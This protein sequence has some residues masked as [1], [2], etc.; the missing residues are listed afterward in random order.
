MPNIYDIAGGQGMQFAQPFSAMVAA[1]QAKANHRL[2]EA[3]ALVMETN[4]ANDER[5]YALEDRKVKVSEAGIGVALERNQIDANEF[6]L[7]YEQWRDK[8]FNGMSEDAKRAFEFWEKAQETGA[9]LYDQAIEQGASEEEA[10]QIANAPFAHMQSQMPQNMRGQAL[11]DPNVGSAIRTRNNR[12]SN[13]VTSKQLVVSLPGQVPREMEVYRIGDKSYIKDANGNMTILRSDQMSSPTQ[14]VE[15]SNLELSKPEI[16]NL[17][18]AQAAGLNFVDGI[19]DAFEILE[20][21]DANTLTARGV[22]VVQDATNEMGALARLMGIKVSAST[23]PGD[24]EGVFKNANLAGEANARMR[25]LITSLAFQAALSYG[26][27]G[28]DVSN[29][30]VEKHIRE[31]G[32]NRSDPAVFKRLLVDNA[33]RIER[34]FKNRWEVAAQDDPSIGPYPE[35]MSK[36]V[37]AIKKKAGLSGV[38]TGDA[39]LGELMDIIGSG[40]ATPQMYQEYYDLAGLGNK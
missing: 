1:R 3:Q 30:D 32:A 24:Y 22:G 11:F 34:N 33:I 6:G 10:T 4:V 16:A 12:S 18:Q 26:S 20:N 19:G 38:K 27:T 9:E 23:N 28:R 40:K 17:R 37:E 36:R 5:D 31:L 8:A 14:R 13:T 39:R 21:V 2:T 35:T 15:N 7:K 25:G 29:Q